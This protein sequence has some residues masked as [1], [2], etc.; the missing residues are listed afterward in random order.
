MTHRNTGDRQ[1]GSGFRYH[2]ADEDSAEY[3]EV[4]L[5]SRDFQGPRDLLSQHQ[6]RYLIRRIDADLN[7]PAPEGIDP[8]SSLAIG[9][10]RDQAIET[11][12]HHDRLHDHVGIRNRLSGVRRDDSAFEDPRRRERK[13]HRIG[14]CFLPGLEGEPLQG[15]S[16][17]VNL[18]LDIRFRPMS[19]SV[20]QPSSSVTNGPGHVERLFAG[21]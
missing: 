20:M 5:A 11:V 8:V 16:F 9:P 14:F 13:R 15:E 7:A 6:V 18:G 12:L 1:S 10:R 2:A 21:S 19:R 3:G 17:V 4:G